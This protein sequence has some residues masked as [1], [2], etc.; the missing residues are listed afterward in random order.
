MEDVGSLEDSLAAIAPTIK[1]TEAAIYAGSHREARFNFNVVASCTARWTSSGKVVPESTKLWGARADAAIQ[2]LEAEAA[3]R[4]AEES[5]PLVTGEGSRGGPKRGF[6]D[7]Q[8]GTKPGT[9]ND[10]KIM[11]VMAMVVIGMSRG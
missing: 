1:R 5:P 11:D 8:R 6:D 7:L 2:Q 4:A 3:Q 9:K 10:S